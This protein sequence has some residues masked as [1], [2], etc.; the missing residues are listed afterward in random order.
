M[1]VTSYT[2]ATVTASDGTQVYPN[3]M[4]TNGNYFSTDGSGNIKDTLGRSPVTKTTNGSQ[5]TYGVL[6]SQNARSNFVVT[7]Q[8]I[9]VSTSFSGGTEYSGTITV[10]Q[11]VQLPDGTTYQFSYDSGT[12]PGHYGLLTGITLPTLGQVTFGHTN[13]TDPIGKINR[14]VSSYGTGSGTRSFTPQVLTP[15][16]SGFTTCQQVTVT[17]PSSDNVVYTFGLNNGAWMSQAQ[18]YSG[19]VSPANL[20]KTIN[21]TWNTSNPCPIPGCTGSAYIQ[22][23][24]TTTTLPVPGGSSI[25]SMVQSTYGSIYSSNVTAFQ[26]W[27]FYTGSPPAIPDRQT[28]ITYGAFNRPLT[29]TACA[30]TGTPPSCTGSSNIAA[31]T[32]FYLQP[33]NINQR[34]GIHKPR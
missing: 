31:K 20:L 6:N 7:T 34:N 11:S 28:D 5:T 9:S 32:V 27:K 23:V 13:F 3:L 8:N 18:Y 4:D 19:A 21:Q 2:T 14:W 22:K 15:C 29:I 26:E 24:S 25:S 1:T 30:P 10:I 33:R 17:K 12:T 16:P